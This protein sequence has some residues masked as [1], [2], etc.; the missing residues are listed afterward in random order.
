MAGLCSLPRPFSS[1]HPTALPCR[2]PAQI[3]ASS[4]TATY[5]TALL[6]PDGAPGPWIQPPGG[7]VHTYQ[8]EPL[9]QPLQALPGQ[10]VL[11]DLIPNDP[12]VGEEPGPKAQEPPW[13][14]TSSHSNTGLHQVLPT[15]PP[16]HFLLWPVQASCHHVSWTPVIAG[17]TSWVAGS[18]HPSCPPPWQP[19]LLVTSGSS[20]NMQSKPSLS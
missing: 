17:V 1:S 16:N 18:C 10:Q 3:S 8:D 14:S 20:S 15:L 9:Q 19:A 6:H 5:P 7:A 2:V 4:S 11:K 13:N 12:Q